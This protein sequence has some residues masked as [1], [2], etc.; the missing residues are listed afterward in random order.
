[1]LPD[2]HGCTGFP[3]LTTEIHLTR[4]APGT[5]APPPTAAAASASPRSPSPPASDTS[6]PGPHAFRGGFRLAAQSDA[7]GAAVFR[8]VREPYALSLAAKGG[9]ASAAAG[10]AAPRRS[11][12]A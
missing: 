10:P 5:A 3:W 12:R 11:R 4:A 2:A 7:Q 1:M 8:A 9:D 6:T